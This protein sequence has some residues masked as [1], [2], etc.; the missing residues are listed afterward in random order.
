LEECPACV[1][2]SAS[3]SGYEITTKHRILRMVNRRESFVE[4]A[5][6]R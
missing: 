5:R 2:L 4:N 1:L 6:L 3:G